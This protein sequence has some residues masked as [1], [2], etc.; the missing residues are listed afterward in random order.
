MIDFEKLRFANAK[1][2]EEWG[3]LVSLSFRGNE[4]AGEV[5]E[6]CNVIK[7]LERARMGLRGSR[8]TVAHLAEELADVIICVDLIATQE[9]ID[10]G[11]AVVAKF[12]ATSEKVG[13][14]TRLAEE[15]IHDGA[16]P[17]TPNVP[18]NVPHRDLF[19]NLPPS[20]SAIYYQ[21]SET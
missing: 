19:G 15:G 5:G 6:A 13:L 1:R 17:T 3:G 11:A 9:G 20:T 16:Q 4:L 2:A 8:D 14:R 21:K 18:R 7:K 12:N 10:L